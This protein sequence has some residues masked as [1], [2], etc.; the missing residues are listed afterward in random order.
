MALALLA[1][2]VAA[3]EQPTAEGDKAASLGSLGS[4]GS[5][6]RPHLLDGVAEAA[7]Q[8]V[9]G[10]KSYVGMLAGKDGMF[11]VRLC[12]DKAN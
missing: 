5:L 2:P 11:G 8:W 1:S 12:D 4:P 6:G 9:L 10:D 7:R 3:A